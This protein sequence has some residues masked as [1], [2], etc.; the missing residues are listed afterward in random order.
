MSER[1]NSLDLVSLVAGIVVAV[2]TLAF[3]V[4]D[5]DT[6]DT[7]ARVVLPAVLLGTGVALLASSRGR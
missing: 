7:Q 3:V 1:R 2:I 6:F 4:G 5:L